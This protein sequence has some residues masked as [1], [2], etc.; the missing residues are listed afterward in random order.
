MLRLAEDTTESYN[1]KITFEIFSAQE[2]STFF[3]SLVC[4]K[5]QI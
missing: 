1:I 3:F 4:A 2:A 5:Y